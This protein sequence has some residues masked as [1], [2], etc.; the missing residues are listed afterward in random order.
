MRKTVLFILLQL[1]LLPGLIF[2][3]Q[4]QEGDFRLE[5][6]SL[7]ATDKGC[8]VSFVAVNQLAATLDKAAVEL[9]VFDGEQLIA[10]MLV[11]ELGKFTKGKTRVIQF[12]LTQKCTQI[13]RLLINGFVECSGPGLGPDACLAGLK[14]SSRSSVEFGS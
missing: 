7:K 11:L 12:D 1:S 13:S 8:R 14:A 6:N 5:L 4:A 9:V 3:A 2:A 10:Q